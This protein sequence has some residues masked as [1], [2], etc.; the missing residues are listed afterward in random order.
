MGAFEINYTTGNRVDM[1]LHSELLMYTLILIVAHF[2]VFTN[3]LQVANRN[4]PGA[5]LGCSDRCPR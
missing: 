2:R 5:T 1:F 4:V 3:G